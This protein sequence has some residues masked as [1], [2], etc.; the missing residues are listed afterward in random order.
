MTCLIEVY[1]PLYIETDIDI[2]V[3]READDTEFTLRTSLELMSEQELTELKSALGTNNLIKIAY[4]EIKEN[5]K[6][7]K[8]Q[9][10]RIEK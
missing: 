6:I 1:A 3:I 9:F 2:S 4:E 8:S 10:V 7:T 5:G